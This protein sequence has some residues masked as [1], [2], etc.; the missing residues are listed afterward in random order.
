MV[1]LRR[2]TR[3]EHPV[4]E[5]PREWLVANGLGGYASATI[6]GA[7]TR[8]Y[9]GFLIAAQP[10]PLGRMVV[11]NDLEV[12]IELE[13]GSV[14]N[15]REKG[16]FLD[17]TLN[18]GLPS[19]RYELDGVV[20]EKSIVVPSRQN[21]V[22]STFRL[23]S[24]GRR[25]RLRLRPLINFR[26]LEAPV[27][28]ALSSGYTLTV[29][30]D[31][32]EV[33]AGPDLPTLRLAVENS[34]GPTF[35]AD[36][37]S[38]REHF[39]EIEAQRGYDS[40]GWLWSPGYFGGEV[41]RDCPLTLIAATE[42]WHTVLALSPDDA[43]TFEAERRRR[44]VG[45]AAAPAQVGFAAELVL[46]ADAFIITPVGRIADGAR[47]RA[48]GDDRR[49]VIAGYH[50]FTDWGRDTMISLPGLCL[51][52]R[53]FDDAKQIL[54]RFLAAASKGMIPNC[55]PEGSEVAEYNSVDAGLWLFVAVWHYLA[56]TGDTAFIHD[57]AM[58]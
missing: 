21:I 13:D 30:G 15:L 47:A 7:I 45:M 38:R 32:Y 40:L 25:V 37:G 18:M 20:I 50:W 57:E 2:A 16:R 44:L 49:T 33:S 9:H 46:A 3:D 55:F 1:D 28:E 36:G 12:D 5:A 43:L 6:T 8:R 48:E 14:V 39:Y 11:L 35:T 4:P 42:A 51:T 19:W 23:L 54:R 26:P 29:R 22:H 52:T 17:F 27:S 24:D 41:R 58:P 53:R 34:E 31:R 56:R 10:A